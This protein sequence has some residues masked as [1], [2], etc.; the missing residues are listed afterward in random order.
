MEHDDM[1]SPIPIATTDGIVNNRNHGIIQEEIGFMDSGGQQVSSNSITTT[2]DDGDNDDDG[3]DSVSDCES[4]ITGSNNNNN[5]NEY[6]FKGLIKVDEG[7]R[8]YVAVSR[9][10]V[11][12]LGSFGLNA[13]VEAIYRN[14]FSGFTNQARLQSFGIFQRSVGAK[15]GGDANVKFAWY[16]ASKEDITRIMSHGFCHSDIV[17]AQDHLSYACGVQLSVLNSPMPR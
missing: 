15:C 2:H 4:V 1:F 6:F 10:L 17:P 3:D 8:L 16:G 11:S 14:R 9:G 5:K 13:N 7:E 12:S